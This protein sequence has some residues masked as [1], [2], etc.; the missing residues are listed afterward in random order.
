MVSVKDKIVNPERTICEVHREIYDLLLDGSINR[1]LTTELIDL[2][3]TAYR[4]GKKMDGKLRQYKHNYDD[5]WWKKTRDEILVEKLGRRQQRQMNP[6][7]KDKDEEL[8]EVCETFTKLGDNLILETPPIEDSGACGQNNIVRT[9]LGKFKRHTSDTISEMFWFQTPK[10]ELK[11]PYYDYEKLFDN[12]KLDVKRLKERGINTIE[13]NFNSKKFLT[14]RREEV[15]E[16]IPGVNL[17]TFIKLNGV[18][19]V[20]YVIIKKLDIRDIQGDYKWD[21]TNNDLVT[22]NFILNG[23]ILNIIDFDDKLIDN[24]ICNDQLQLKRIVYEITKSYHK[25]K[26]D[27]IKLNLGCG[28]DIKDGYIN[29]DRYNNTGNVDMNEDIGDLPF[30]DESVDEIYTSHVFEHIP[31]NE[32]Y[33]VVEEWKR[34]LKPNGDLILRLPNLEYEVKMWLN[35]PDEDKWTEVHRI[36]GA[37]SHPGNT[38][39]CGFNPG[40]LSSFI[41]SFDFEIVYVRDQNRGHG[42]EIGLHAKKKEAAKKTNVN[43]TCHFVDGPFIDIQGEKTNNY[44]VVDFSDPEVNTTVHQQLL[45]VNRWTRP[46]RKYY[47]DWLVQI[48]RNGKLDFEHCFDL[49]NKNVLISFDTKGIGD[50]IAWIPYIEEFRNKHNCNVWISTFWN[51]LF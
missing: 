18:Y 5:N 24:K 17:K 23:S 16:W 37:Q 41:K 27:K 30:D 51:K 33:G 9:N 29:I 20:F 39:F 10:S 1:K 12:K 6:I 19:P 31:I 48:R 34:V 49:K 35:T 28:N 14:T 8:S 47:T 11:W 26:E 4:M 7:N 25:P 13:S 22:H 21:N 2:L 36:F 44:F 15:K 32:I 43:Y 42:N 40:S 50:T 46:H 38:H 45:K 3:E